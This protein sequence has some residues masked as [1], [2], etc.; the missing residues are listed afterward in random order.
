MRTAPPPRPHARQG[1]LEVRTQ[2]IKRGVRLNERCLEWPQLYGSK[3]GGE[4]T[5]KLIADLQ[6]FIQDWLATVEEP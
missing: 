5:K 2:F 6:E 4:I 1:E 3:Y